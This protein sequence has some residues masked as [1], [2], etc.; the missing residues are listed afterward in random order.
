MV[1][2]D[3]YITDTS[4]SMIAH[5]LGQRAWPWCCRPASGQA[6]FGNHLSGKKFRG[7][8]TYPGHDHDEVSESAD[9]LFLECHSKLPI[10]LK[11][12][13]RES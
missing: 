6:M 3:R 1:V 7:R 11:I 12:V 2:M 5:F 9:D 4:M 10:Q 8:S 13:G